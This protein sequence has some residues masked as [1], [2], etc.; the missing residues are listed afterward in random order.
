MFKILHAPPSHTIVI[1]IIEAT[2]VT[3]YISTVTLYVSK[4][5]MEF[6]LDIREIALNE[7]CQHNDCNMCDGCQGKYTKVS[8]KHRTPMFLSVFVSSCI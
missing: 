6:V 4:I 1:C 5:V 3:Q 7:G 8:R 2:F